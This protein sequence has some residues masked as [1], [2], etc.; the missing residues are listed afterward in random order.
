VKDKVG[1]IER[2]QRAKR[3]KRVKS[4]NRRRANTPESGVS[5]QSLSKPM[6]GLKEDRLKRVVVNSL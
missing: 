6:T 2:R 5:A 4:R 1:R 3:A